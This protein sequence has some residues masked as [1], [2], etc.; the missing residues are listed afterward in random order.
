[1][2]KII[3]GLQLTKRKELARE[4]QPLLSEYGCNIKTRVGLHDV[5]GNKC[6][7]AGVILLEM[8]GDIG[9]ID[10]FKDKINKVDGVILKEMKF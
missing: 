5:E 3:I 4:I 9:K 7:E 6:S 1:M 10:E 8:Y 2:S